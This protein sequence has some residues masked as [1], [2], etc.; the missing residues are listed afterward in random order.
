M[1]DFTQFWGWSGGGATSWDQRESERSVLKMAVWSEIGSTFGR[2]VM[3]DVGRRLSRVP[4]REASSSD[5]D[6]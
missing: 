2:V 5:V 6:L 3:S 1:R 4:W